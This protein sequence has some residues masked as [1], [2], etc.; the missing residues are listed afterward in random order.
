[1]CSKDVNG[2][3]AL[4]NRR[5]LKYMHVSSVQNQS[6]TVIDR[7]CGHFYFLISPQPEFTKLKK[8]PI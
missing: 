7:G 8:A 6:K 2:Y 3:I 4:I 5:N 1:M